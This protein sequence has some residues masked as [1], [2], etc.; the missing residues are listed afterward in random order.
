MP[1]EAIYFQALTG[2]CERFFAAFYGFRFSKAAR[3]EADDGCRL[4]Q[5]AKDERYKGGVGWRVNHAG[6]PFCGS[7]A[8]S[9]DMIQ[10]VLDGIFMVI[11]I[12]S[13]TPSV[14]LR[15]PRRPLGTAG[16]DAWPARAINPT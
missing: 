16:P 14:N 6:F 2:S 1:S 11:P 7:L 8:G 10:D 15:R 4:S 5:K 9:S 12:G 13:S 3:A